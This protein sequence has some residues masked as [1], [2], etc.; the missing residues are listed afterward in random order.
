MSESNVELF[1]QGLAAWNAGDHRAVVDMCR[2]DVEWTFSDRLPDATG[3]IRGRAAVERFLER[4]V[5][6]W[7]DIRISELRLAEGEDR[8]VAEVEFRAIGREGIEVTI[9]FAHCWVAHEGQVTAFRA[10]ASFDEALEE[11]GLTG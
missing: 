11:M 6:D 1:R 3:T 2:P 4:F 5:H 9:T 10:Y 8:V 7:T